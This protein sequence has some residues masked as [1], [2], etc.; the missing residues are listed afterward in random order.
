MASSSRAWSPLL[1]DSLA[2][3]TVATGSVAAAMQPRRMAASKG[4]PAATSSR[5]TRKVAPKAA[6]MDIQRM[7]SPLW[8]R[9][10]RVSLPPSRKPII[11]RASSAITANWSLRTA[12]IRASASCPSRMPNSSNRVTRGRKV[13][14]PSR[15]VAM[16]SSMIPPTASRI[17]AAESM[18]GSFA[19]GWVHGVR[20]TRGRHGCMMDRRSCLMVPF[21]PQAVAGSDD[22]R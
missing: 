19:T 21:S 6:R 1:P 5:V 18:M 7:A 11:T 17:C 14:L 10:W 15:S 9:L 2:V 8:F 4:M 16:L 12:G 3:S 13:R 22:R 20:L